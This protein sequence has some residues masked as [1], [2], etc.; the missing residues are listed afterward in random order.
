MSEL[1]T[2]IVVDLAG[3][4]SRNASRY[5]KSLQQFSNKGRRHLN[6]LS[7]TAQR[8]GKMLDG[9]G[10]RYTAMLAGGFGAYAAKQQLNKSGQLDKDLTKLAQSASETLDKIAP[11]RE[12][13]W[14]LS[15]DTG[16]TI[17]ELLGGLSAL[18][19]SGQK[20]DEALATIG[21]VNNAMAVTGA[22]ADILAD[23]MTSAATHFN[24]DLSKPEMAV[25]LLDKMTVAGRMGNAELE[26]LSSIFSRVGGNAKAA[27]LSFDD[28]LGLIEKMSMLEKNPERLAT[29]VDSTLRIF[30]NQNYLQN[31]QDVTK[32]S[33]Y[34]A[35]KQKREAFDVLDDIAAKYK[36]LKNDVDRD[37]S[38]ALAFG[39]TDLDTIKGLRQ[40]L[41]GN[42]IAEARK[43]S[44]KISKAG[45]TIAKDLDD[46]LNNSIDQVARLKAALGEAVEPFSKAINEA[47][48]NAIKYLIDEKKLTG[49]EM[50]AGGAMGAAALFAGAKLGS[51]VLKKMGDTG[52][53][54]AKGKALEELAGVTPVYVVNM[55]GGFGGSLDGG[56]KKK[57][58]GVRAAS[59]NPG[60]W[61]LL[62]AAPSMAALRTMGMGAM[63]TA[64]LAVTGAGAVGYGAGSLGYKLFL[65]GGEFS[66]S[67]GRAIATALAAVGNDNAQAALAS[68]RRT[69]EVSGT[70]TLSVQDD[71][72]AV[73][74]LKTNSSV[75]FEVDTGNL[76]S[77]M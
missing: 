24:F 4:L 48:V 41:S 45:G 44:D 2:S 51:S 6:T 3:N 5:T 67:L 13:I 43:M 73:K 72:I 9:M 70:I 21:G 16:K 8:T 14:Q 28:T 58:G 20:W 71:R 65:E 27:N 59:R 55:P 39:Q 7:A 74:E 15:K 54:V 10:N 18:I 47:Q 60:R 77:A 12:Y 76:M 49:G 11:L 69:E 63:G 37:A 66:N 29:L 34:D 36:T 32:V 25:E 53:G 56:L 17:P 62:R 46:A 19:A 35:D 75:D 68:E 1:K 33:F 64:G 57:G 40:L 52:I 61:N 50:I 38:I 22:Q 30:T 31:A 23:A 26:N 42:T